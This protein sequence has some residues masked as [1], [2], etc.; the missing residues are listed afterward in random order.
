MRLA[1]TRRTKGE[2]GLA[3]FVILLLIL[4]GIV[5]WLY[6]SRRDA[7][8]SAHLF[9]AE[10]AKRVAV[11]FDEKYL[12]VNLS[13]DAQKTYLKSARARLLERL[14]EMGV[15]AQPIEVE[16]QVYFTSYFFDP[17]GTYHAKLKYPT[18]S[19]QLDMDISRGMTVWQVDSIILPWTPEQTSTPAPAS[20]VASPTPTPTPTPAPQQKSRRKRNR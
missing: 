12:H 9:A 20:V 10:V 18:T 6:S 14:R 8:K 1:R 7:E 5:W 16:G 15:P 17:R 19:A 4:A 3:L 11:N 2:G 13:P